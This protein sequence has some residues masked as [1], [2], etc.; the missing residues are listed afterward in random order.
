MMRLSNGW[1]I[2]MAVAGLAIVPGAAFAAPSP[3]A[4]SGLKLA[5]QY[6]AGCH[7]VSPSSKRGWTD[8]PAFDA[9]ANRPGTTMAGLNAIIRK[10]HMKMLN[11]DRPPQEANDIAT[12]ILTLRKQ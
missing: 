10:P 7:Q 8:A 2:L 1:T 5:Q 6:C 12:Y 4:A 9:I 11:T 3:Q